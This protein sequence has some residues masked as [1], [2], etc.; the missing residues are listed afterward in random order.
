[1]FGRIQKDCLNRKG[2]I[3][4]FQYLEKEKYKLAICSSSHSEYVQTLVNTVSYLLQFETIIGR[5][6]VKY[7]KPN[8][9]IF[10]LGAKV[11]NVNPKECLVSEDSKAG[12]LAAKKA[13][14]HSI[15]IEDTIK[16]DNDF[17]EA[18]DFKLDSLLDVVDLLGE[19]KHVGT[20][21]NFMQ[22]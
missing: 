5:D 7:A 10:L 4:L 20:M 22:R 17:K 14:I 8:P 6:M 11:L 2:L 18:I 12:I 19:N 13:G 16:V 3:P 9:D 21:E 1:M 15:F